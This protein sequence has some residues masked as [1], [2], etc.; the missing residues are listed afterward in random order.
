[1]FRIGIP[2]RSELPDRIPRHFNAAGMPDGWGAK[3]G[4]WTP[5]VIAAVMYAF[6]TILLG[7]PQRFKVPFQIDRH[8]PEV[9]SLLRRM[10]MVVRVEMLLMF[11]YISWTT[12]ETALGNA[13]GLGKSFLPLVTTG[14]FTPVVYYLVRLRQY[15]Q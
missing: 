15:K 13:H 1:M 8:N 12:I 9:L 3:N 6:L 11:A 5:P 14:A 10:M 2:Q 7:F 4:I